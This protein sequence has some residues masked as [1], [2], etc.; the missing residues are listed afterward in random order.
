[1]CVVNE[2]DEAT[3]SGASGEDTAVCE[4][5]TLIELLKID[6]YVLKMSS[7]EFRAVVDEEASAPMNDSPVA[8]KKRVYK[9]NIRAR[10]AER[11]KDTR[12]HVSALVKMIGSQLDPENSSG[13]YVSVMC[14]T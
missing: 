7:S 14:L 2:A 13:R 1:M 10:Q 9:S 12:N 3:M 5:V 8:R 11:E 4:Y 6:S